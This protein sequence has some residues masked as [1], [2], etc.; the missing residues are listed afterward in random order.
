MSNIKEVFYKGQ[1][2]G[3]VKNCTEFFQGRGVY[4]PQDKDGF[5]CGAYQATE[6]QA[7]QAVIK[8]HQTGEYQK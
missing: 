1:K 2:I 6:A 8:Y 7:E 3:F 5:V 4:Q